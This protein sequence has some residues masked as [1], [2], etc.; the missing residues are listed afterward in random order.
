MEIP[1]PEVGRP[2]LCFPSITIEPMMHLLVLG[3]PAKPLNKK[4]SKVLP[5]TRLVVLDLLR[6]QTP[7]KVTGSE[8]GA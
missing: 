6:L 8:L 4:V 3:H 5:S 2:R 7:H 1:K